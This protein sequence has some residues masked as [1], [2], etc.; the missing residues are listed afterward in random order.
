MQ[1][2]QGQRRW[3]RRPGTLSERCPALVTVACLALF[4]LATS[5]PLAAW[6]EAAGTSA[7]TAKAVHAGALALL[8]WGMRATCGTCDGCGGE[9]SRGGW[10]SEA[11]LAVLGALALAGAFLPGVGAYLSWCAFTGLAEEQLLCGILWPCLRTALGQERSAL[12]AA[13][14]LFAACHLTSMLPLSWM[15]ARVAFAAA[16]GI[17]MVWLFRRTGRLW[18]CVLCHAAFDAAFFAL[19]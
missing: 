1:G 19:F 7:E 14:A 4:L 13:S 12:L 2:Q 9:G 6:V 18:P 3:R 5:L 11:P 16:F 15:L 17:C 8:A 10:R